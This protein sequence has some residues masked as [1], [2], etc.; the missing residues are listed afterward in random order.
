MKYL[1]AFLFCFNAYSANQ[2]PKGLRKIEIDCGEKSVIT[3]KNFKKPQGC[4]DLG[5]PESVKLYFDGG[6]N[7]DVRILQRLESSVTVMDEGPHIDLTKWK[8]SYSKYKWLPRSKANTYT[9]LPDLKLGPFPK[10]T[11]AEL[12]EALKKEMPE[13][14]VRW[15]EHAKKCGDNPK[16]DPCD[17]GTSAFE[18]KIYI[19]SDDKPLVI[20]YSVPMGC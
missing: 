4:K 12:Q 3:K 20:K 1:I 11:Q 10:I 13:G 18:F 2:W 9:T 16:Q 6:V 19:D 17:V 8:H 5:V 15:Q 14:Y 7:P